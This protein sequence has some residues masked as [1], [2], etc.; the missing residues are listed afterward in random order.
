MIKRIL[1]AAVAAAVV[2]PA[3]SAAETNNVVVYGK[4]D[5]ALTKANRK[6]DNPDDWF[7]HE[8]GGASKLGFKGTED[9]G[10]GLKAIW[11]MEFDIPVGRTTNCDDVLMIVASSP[12]AATSTRTVTPM[13]VWPATGVLP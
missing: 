12:A 2:I 4:V 8:N 7:V 10:G 9:L 11:K 1:A 13:S 3:A 5:V 6:G